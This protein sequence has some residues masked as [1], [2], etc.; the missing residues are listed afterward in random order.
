M[1]GDLNTSSGN[2]MIMCLLLWQFCHDYDI[3]AS[4]L[5][6]GDD[7]VLIMEREDLGKINKLS[8]YAQELGFRL[9]IDGPYSELNAIPFCQTQCLRVGDGHRMVRICPAALA[10]DM[11]C[12]AVQ[13]FDAYSKWLYVIGQAGVATYGDV[14][15]L[16]A[17]YRACMRV[18]TASRIRVEGN[19]KYL[20]RGMHSVG[21]EI[22]VHCRLDF[23]EAFGIP[24]WKQL[25]LEEYFDGLQGLFCRSH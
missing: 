1:S 2:C 17:W 19:L 18:G 10:K 21:E 14:P 5:N 8:M 9:K 3:D 11:I 7:A 20:S 15:V 16:S 13:D 23:A 22:T 6:N 24:V 4:L 12:L 25:A